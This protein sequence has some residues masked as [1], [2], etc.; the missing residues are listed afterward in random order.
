MGTCGKDEY[1][2][3]LASTLHQHKL[4]YC[5]TMICQEHNHLQNTR[6]GS[7]HRGQEDCRNLATVQVVTTTITSRPRTKFLTPQHPQ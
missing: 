7:H 2:N 6:V 1:T 3:S 4:C 5:G